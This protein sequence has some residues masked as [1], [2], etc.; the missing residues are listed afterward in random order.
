M[1]MNI[2]TGQKTSVNQI[3]DSL[4]SIIGYR[5][6]PLHSAPRLGDVYQISLETTRAEKELGWK[7]QVQLEDGLRRTVEFFRETA[8]AAR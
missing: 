4:K 7:A 1:A 5:W 8:Q 2:G 3:F 6:D